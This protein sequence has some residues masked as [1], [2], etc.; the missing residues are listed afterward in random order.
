MSSIPHPS[1]SCLPA[2]LAA[3][4]VGTASA[5]F[6]C[7]ARAAG[8][9]AAGRH[10]APHAPDR[11][12]RAAHPAAAGHRLDSSGRRQ[13]GKASYYGSEFSGRKMADGTRMD[14]KGRNAASKTLPLGTKAKVTNLETG[15][16]TVVTIKDRGPYVKGRIVDLSPATAKE[17]G[18]TKKDG[19]AD[20]EVV[21]ISVPRPDGSVKAGAAADDRRGDK[22]DAADREKD[23]DAK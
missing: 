3:C 2:L 10:A 18:I 11:S 15:K 16:S 19:V 13:V 12:R 20:V 1:R 22:A 14:P 21:P 6:A 9:E 17:V 8:K 4:I 5:G 23:K 7:E